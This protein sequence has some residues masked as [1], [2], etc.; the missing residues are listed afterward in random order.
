MDSR[1]FLFE[2]LIFLFFISCHPFVL[3]QE[4]ETIYGDAPILASDGRE[5]NYMHKTDAELFAA[6]RYLKSKIAKESNNAAYYLE[7]SEIY[8]ALFD[9][10]R[11][12]KGK[13]FAEWIS[14]SADALEKAVMIDPTNK[15]AHFNLGIV[16]KRQGKMEKARE[17]LKKTI[18]LCDPQLDASVA[19][20]SWMEIGGIYA[21]QGF[22]D[23]A[24]ESFLKAREYDFSNLDVQEAIREVQAK[25]QQDTGASSMPLMAPSMRASRMSSMGPMV[26]PDPHLDAGTQYPG[27]QALPY[28]GSLLAQQFGGGQ[29]SNGMDDEKR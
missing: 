4:E 2:F 14:R 29:Q 24:R 16:Y 6:E 22:W 1:L 15:I 5:K 13:Q 28:L 17:E 19:F 26:A 9:K 20:A 18:R 12:Q 7:L 11:T 25:K 10:T 8:A 23:E 21:D 3:A 27:A